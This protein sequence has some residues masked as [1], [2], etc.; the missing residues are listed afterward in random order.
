MPIGLKDEEKFLRS[1]YSVIFPKEII[2]ED[3]EMNFILF[4]ALIKSLYCRFDFSV[5]GREVKFF[6]DFPLKVERI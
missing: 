6:I 1:V 4:D 5:N 2:K 3:I